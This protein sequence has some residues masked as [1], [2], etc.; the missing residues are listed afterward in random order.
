MISQENILYLNTKKDV[1]DVHYKTQN[2]HKNELNKEDN[3]KSYLKQLITP[4]KTEKEEKE[5]QRTNKT[6]RKQMAR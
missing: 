4:K 2:N 6:N 5:N 1:R 3:I